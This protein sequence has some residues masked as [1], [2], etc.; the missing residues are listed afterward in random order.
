MRLSGAGEDVG[1]GSKAREGDSGGPGFVCCG[2]EMQ[3][4]SQ[5]Y[6]TAKM[7]GGKKPEN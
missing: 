2:V 1:P 4:S 7:C 6:L 5:R 3:R